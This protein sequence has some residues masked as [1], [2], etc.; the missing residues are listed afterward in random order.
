MY[1]PYTFTLT[2]DLVTFP[3]KYITSLM[4][5][6]VLPNY[7]H[8]YISKSTWTIIQ[9]LLGNTSTDDLTRIAVTLQNVKETE[10]EKYRKDT[11]LSMYS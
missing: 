6:L 1:A 5:N 3:P 2:V 4:L 9:H 10:I 7:I 11:H 8:I